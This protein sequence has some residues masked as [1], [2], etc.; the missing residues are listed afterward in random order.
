MS[1]LEGTAQSGIISGLVV[2]V[3]G[4]N[5]AQLDVSAGRGVIYDWSSGTGIPVKTFINFA[6]VFVLGI[7]GNEVTGIFVGY[8]AVGSG[9]GGPGATLVK[10]I[11][12]IE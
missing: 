9:G 10:K 2:T 1:I 4:G 7:T 3:N 8:T 5:P 11:R 6:G 12:L